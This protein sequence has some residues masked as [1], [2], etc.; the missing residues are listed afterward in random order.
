MRD[1]PGTGDEAGADRY[2]TLALPDAVGDVPRFS[3][4]MWLKAASGILFSRSD[5]GA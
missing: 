5:D 1:A 4:R 2:R 3:I